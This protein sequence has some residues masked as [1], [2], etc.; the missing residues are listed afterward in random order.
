MLLSFMREHGLPALPPA[1]HHHDDLCVSFWRYAK[2]VGDAVPDAAEAGRML[3]E[4][5]GALRAYPGEL[6]LLAPP[7]SDIPRGLERL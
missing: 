1:P 2:P 5:H 4:L 3:A 7:L 6:P